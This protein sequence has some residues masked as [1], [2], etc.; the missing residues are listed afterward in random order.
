MTENIEN[1]ILEHL[2]AI[3]TDI[4]QIKDDLSMVAQ[5]ITSIE[6]QVAQLHLDNA[7]VHSRIDGV[8]KRLDRIDRW[9]ELTP[10]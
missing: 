9:L 8:E 2:P 4:G 6:T 3:R 5:R 7:I 10:L 1:L